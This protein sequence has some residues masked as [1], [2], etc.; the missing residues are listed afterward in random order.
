MRLVRQM[1]LILAT[2]AAALVL[3]PSAASAATLSAPSLAYPLS[4]TVVD[5]ADVFTP[6][7]EAQLD[8]QFRSI[9]DKSD[10]RIAFLVDTVSS[11]EGKSISD[12][13]TKR[14]DELGIKPLLEGKGVFIILAPNDGQV[15]FSV[16][17]DV[18]SRV[19][20]ETSNAIIKSQVTPNFPS[21]D[22]YT[23]V[24]NGVTGITDAYKANAPASTLWYR[25]GYV[26]PVTPYV[27]GG[28]AV[29]VGVIIVLAVLR[30]RKEKITLAPATEDGASAT[31]EFMP[32]A[33]IIGYNSSK[34]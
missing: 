16:G 8:R 1:S 19:S 18:T 20:N 28:A 2:L 34:H 14:V 27:V 17:A 21:G 6:E 31:A 30:K 5:T 24:T 23:G 22:Y 12:Y 29:L 32:F 10:T 11:L 33:N 26:Q 3:L 13:A 15:H 7:Q 25:A 9:Y 4:K